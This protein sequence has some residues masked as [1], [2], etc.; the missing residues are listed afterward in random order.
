MSIAVIGDTNIALGFSMVGVEAIEVDSKEEVE[1]ALNE[2]LERPELQILL[3]TQEAAELT[4]E[5]VDSLKHGALDTIVLELPSGGEDSGRS[6]DEL[7][8]MATG[9][10]LGSQGME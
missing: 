8:E 7:V 2:Q 1:A 4:R 9:I 10:S 3:I 6:L 5:R